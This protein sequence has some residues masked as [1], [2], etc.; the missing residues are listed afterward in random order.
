MKKISLS[1]ITILIL[2]SCASI[3]NGRQ[4]NVK[5]SAD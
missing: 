5:I 1:L 2:N 4:T 3:L